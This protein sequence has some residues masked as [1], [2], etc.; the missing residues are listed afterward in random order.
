MRVSGVPWLARTGVPPP[1][2]Q[3]VA[4]WSSD[5]TARYVADTPLE[6][7]SQ[8]Y[9]EAATRD[10][11]TVVDEARKSHTSAEGARSNENDVS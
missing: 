9:R 3:L 2:I 8:V 1:L 5:V 4:R 6:T 11:R 7:I 10:L